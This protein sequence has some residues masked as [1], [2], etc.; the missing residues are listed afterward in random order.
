MRKRFTLSAIVPLLFVL[1]LISEQP[2]KAYAD[3]GSGA[4]LVQVIL[5][6]L[7]GGLFHLKKMTRWIRRRK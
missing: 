5:G 4:M 1:I 3:P 6:G 2:L 7:L